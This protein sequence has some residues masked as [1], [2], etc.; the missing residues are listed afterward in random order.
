MA[1]TAKNALI[2]IGL[3]IF[4]ILAALFMV[5]AYLALGEWGMDKGDDKF[6]QADPL[7][8]W[9]SIPG[10]DETYHRHEW[11][12]QVKMNSEGFRDQERTIEKSP[13]AFRIAVIG[14]S[15]VESLQVNYEDLFTHL[16]ESKL[17]SSIDRYSRVEVMNFGVMGYGTGQELLNFREHVAKYSPD[18]VVLLFYP[19]NDVYDNRVPYESPSPLYQRPTFNLTGDGRIEHIPVNRSIAANASTQVD[20][21]HSSLSIT[22]KA[23]VAIETKALPHVSSLLYNL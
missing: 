1:G 3:S 20:D 23:V 8:G 2:G 22:E 21:Y 17:N 5:E 13:G 9:S 10:L 19:E 16:L 4:G 18:M 11:T 7:L 15:F 12:T 6:R 14:D